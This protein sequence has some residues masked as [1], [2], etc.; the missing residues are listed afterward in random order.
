MPCL[1]LRCPY[2]SLAFVAAKCY[3]LV[4]RYRY[5]NAHLIVEQYFSSQWIIH[6]QVDERFIYFFDELP[7]KPL[8]EHSLITALV[9]K[10]LEAATYTR[11]AIFFSMF[12]SAR[13]VLLAPLA[14]DLCMTVFAFVVHDLKASHLCYPALV[15]KNLLMRA[16]CFPMLLELCFVDNFSALIVAEGP[17]LLTF[18]LY[19]AFK[20]NNRQI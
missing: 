4:L 9:L 19:V 8:Y 2:L 1:I 15:T 6:E 3:V 5:F 18:A 16:L 12:R 20:P 14:S 11:D 7:L 13:V 10:I 17:C